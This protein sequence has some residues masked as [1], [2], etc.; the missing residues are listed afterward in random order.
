MTNTA[1]HIDYLDAMG[2]QVWV[3]R[4]ALSPQ[5]TQEQSQGQSLAK[6]SKALSIAEL[7]AMVAACQRCEV[8]KT[9]QQVVFGEG[10]V[11]ASWVII[12]SYPSALDDEQGRPFSG[13]PGQLLSAMLS[14][15]DA[16]KQG[17]YLTTGA[18]CYAKQPAV[19]NNTELAMCREYLVQQIALLSPK[20]I[21]VMG[22][23]VAQSLLKSTQNLSQLRG[24]V[25]R[26]DDIPFPIIVSHELDELLKNPLSKKASWSDLALASGIVN[27]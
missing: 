6:S 21:F 12:G 25:Q 24:A 16:N 20:V 26:V 3:E 13:T 4:A 27:G 10:S 22:E 17:V 14:A 5:V 8:S 18:K 19:G 15:V 2:V 9:R 1:R 23:N 7:T 11:Q